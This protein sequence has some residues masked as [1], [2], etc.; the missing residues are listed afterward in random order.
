[1][2]FKEL[3]DKIRVLLDEYSELKKKNRDLEELLKNKGLELEE[4]NRKIRE[5][6]EE[7]NTVRTK[8]DSLL[9]LLQDVDVRA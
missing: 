1:M 8:I 6:N 7:R 3:E 4:A 9:E 5:L 2:K